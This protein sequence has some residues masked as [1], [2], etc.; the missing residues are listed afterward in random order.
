MDVP[1]PVSSSPNPP[2]SWIRLCLCGLALAACSSKQRDSAQRD[3]EPAANSATSIPWR[4]GFRI[5]DA[6]RDVFIPRPTTPEGTAIT[7]FI[8]RRAQDVRTW[9]RIDVALADG[10]TEVLEPLDA[11]ADYRLVPRPTAGI[12]LVVQSASAEQTRVIG[13]LSGL[14]IVTKAALQAAP[15]VNGKNALVVQWGE[16]E[17]TRS[18]TQLQALPTHV[19][20]GGGDKLGWSLADAMAPI[21]PMGS[22]DRIEVR[23][24]D[25]TMEFAAREL[26]SGETLVLLRHNSRGELR[27]K[28]IRGGQDDE[29]AGLRNV[30][31]V[32]LHP[33]RPQN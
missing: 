24:P 28:V 15:S 21:A 5:D 27:L 23:S 18:A 3:P 25:Q 12:N 16:T 6:P 33:Q 2:V 29:P 32:I 1:P 20:P 11:S 17:Q 19:M 10:R 13:P 8:A 30:I 26:E 31:R 9:E 22:L 7:S 4:I 14:R